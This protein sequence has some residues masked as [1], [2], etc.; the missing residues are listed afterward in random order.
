[1]MSARHTCEDCG[2]PASHETAD[3]VW[4]CD[5]DYELLCELAFIEDYDE[6]ALTTS[7]KASGE[8]R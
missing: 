4:L 1:M 3:G 8:A 6:F 2:E 5:G 7:T